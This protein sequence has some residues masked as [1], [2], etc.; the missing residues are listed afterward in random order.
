MQP[1]T[2]EN[3]TGLKPTESPVQNADAIGESE[4]SENVDELTR[5]RAHALFTEQQLNIYRRTDRWFAYL[6]IFQWFAGIAAAFWVSPLAWS[7]T[8][9]E[10]HIHVWAA[11]FLGGAISLL[12][13]Y[14]GLRLPGATIT[15]HTIAAGQMLTSALLIHL[16]GG[17]IETHFHVF[18]S[19]AFLS[20][21]RDWKVLV[22]ASAVIGAD[23][24]WRGIYFPQSVYG[25]LTASPWR[26]LEHVGWVL[27]EDV[28]LALGITESTKEMK[29]IAQRRAELELTNKIVEAKVID[30]TGQLSQRAR[31]LE[32]LNIKLTQSEAAEKAL[33]NELSRSNS[34]LEQFAY[35]ASHDLQEPLRKVVSFG[36]RLRESS[37]G[38]LSEEALDSLQRM[39]SAAARMKQMIGALLDLSRISNKSSVVEAVDL[40]GAVDHVLS[41]LEVSVQQSAAHVEIGQLPIVYGNRIQLEQLLS[42]LI[43]N[44]LKFRRPEIAPVIKISA[45]TAIGANRELGPGKICQ[46]KIEDNGI[47][48]E[49]QDKERIFAI[50]QRLH[51]RS[52]YEGSGIGLALCRKIALR[53]GG[54]ITASGRPGSGSCFVV[55]LQLFEKKE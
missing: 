38:Q 39:Q 54:D 6:M 31:E 44:A 8:V 50:F 22:T 15:R 5:N 49:E 53:H 34:D 55:E 10:T 17:R 47:G 40:R 43:G 16:T 2:A 12:P 37:E 3:E 11:I 51:A 20:F 45:E 36:D 27:F 29:D 26:W 7:G 4:G 24:L 42:N 32:E 30:R 1:V 13:I 21:Y 23:H 25:T 41:D 9:S 46:L 28:F 33:V 48:F 14:L 18:G 52:E 35:I 19:L